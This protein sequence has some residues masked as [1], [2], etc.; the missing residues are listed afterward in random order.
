M[1]ISSFPGTIAEKTVFSSLNGLG[2]LVKIYLTI[3]VRVY[4]C[5]LY[6]S[7]CLYVCLY[8][9]TTLF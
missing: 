1:W 8:A 5:V 7:I 3:Y 9:S 6:S 2:N 4:V